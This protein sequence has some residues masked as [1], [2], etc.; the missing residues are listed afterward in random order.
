MNIKTLVAE[1]SAV[2]RRLLSCHLQDWGFEFVIANDGSEAWKMLQQN[3]SLHLAILDWV[4]P[5]I[6]GIDLCRRIRQQSSGDYIYTILLTGKRD[7][8]DLLAAME[9]GAD[10]YITKPFDPSELRVRILAGKRIIELQHQLLAAQDSLKFAATHDALTNIWNRAEIIAFLQREL[11][12]SKREG[13]WVATILIDVDHFKKVNDLLGH[14]AGDAVLKEVCSRLR[15]ELRIYDGLGRYGGEE[16]LVVLP[17]CELDAAIRRADKLRDLVAGKTISWVH[18]KS[19]VTISAG[20]AVS[21]GEGPE[22]AENILHKADTA[23]YRA[24]ANG[25][26]RVEWYRSSADGDVKELYHAKITEAIPQT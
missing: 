26:N 20:L 22:Q 10:D 1:D 18:G 25:R 11:A 19:S 9:A 16:F 13:S 6:S 5:G 15:A 2:Y 3:P 7:Q 24:K 14:L 21:L 17:G 23:L 12:R 8:K 4:L